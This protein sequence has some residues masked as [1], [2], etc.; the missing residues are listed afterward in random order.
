MLVLRLLGPQIAPGSRRLAVIPKKVIALT[1]ASAFGLV[2][3]PASA[4]AHHGHA[5]VVVAGGYYA[6]PFW[7]GAGWYS[8]WY[9]PFWPYG[10]YPYYYPYYSYDPTS[11]LKLKVT[12]KDA[13]V[14]VDGSYAG[15]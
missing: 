5:H 11:A 6:S 4:Q 8:S 10:P 7:S 15:I 2:A 1:A 13:E 3:A 14:Y 9:G 12:P